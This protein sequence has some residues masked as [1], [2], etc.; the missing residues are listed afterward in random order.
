MTCHC[1]GGVGSC[2]G[3]SRLLFPRSWLAV[4]QPE[5]F[6]YTAPPRRDYASREGRDAVILTFNHRLDLHYL[7]RGDAK[8]HE[9]A[10]GFVV[11][12]HDLSAVSCGFESQRSQS[13]EKKGI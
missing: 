3:D 7:Y 8:S 4:N 12:I 6:V 13:G 9:L 1:Y 2:L 10:S 11:R 5:L